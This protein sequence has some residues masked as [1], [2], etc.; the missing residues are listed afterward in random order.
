MSA[1]SKLKS[2]R[3]REGDLQEESYSPVR[4]G[5]LRMRHVEVNRPALT[6]LQ[7]EVTNPAPV[8]PPGGGMP[9]CEWLI[10]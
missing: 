6:F 5:T 9:T 3:T 8:D 7:G 4:A 1:G 10:D 2:A